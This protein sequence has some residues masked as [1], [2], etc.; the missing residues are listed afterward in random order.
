MI[1]EFT[2]LQPTPQTVKLC[3]THTF[4][5][6]IQSVTMDMCVRTLQ[7]VMMRCHGHV[8][9]VN[10]TYCMGYSCATWHCR[11]LAW[12]WCR[13]RGLQCGIR[14]HTSYSYMPQHV[15]D[16]L[17]KYN[18]TVYYGTL[19]VML[20]VVARRWTSNSCMTQT[21]DSMAMHGCHDVLFRWC[22]Y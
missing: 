16:L 12:Q 14:T 13:A 3:G 7:S 8:T 2:Q 20:I 17:S 21:Q 18:R 22:N 15:T 5:I 1:Y 11:L 6:H 10:H 9:C 4:N 19:V